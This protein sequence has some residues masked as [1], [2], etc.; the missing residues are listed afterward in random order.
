MTEKK[1]EI[2]ESLLKYVIQYLEDLT[3]PSKSLNLLVNDLKKCQPSQQELE[4]D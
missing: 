2:K 1:Y 4:G 3:I